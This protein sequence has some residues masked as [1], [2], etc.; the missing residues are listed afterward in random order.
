MIDHMNKTRS[1]HII[2]IEDPIEILHPDQGCIVNQR[3][4]G[5]DTTDFGQAL[6]R[7]LRQD[8]DVILIGELRD[9]ETAETALQAAESGHLVLSTMHTIDAAETVSRMV[10]FFPTGKQQQIRSILAGVLRGVISQRLLPRIGGGRVA[11]VEVMVANSRIQEL[12]R[13]NKPEFV[14]EAIAEG[15]FFQMQTLTKALIDLVISGDVDEETA[16]A[17]APNRHDFTIALARALKEHAVR[18]GKE[19][20]KEEDPDGA[21]V[22]DGTLLRVDNSL[23][24]V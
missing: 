17:A 18:E 21:A 11:A 2:T 14:P 24:V 23:R 12:I 7:A 10:E 20:E 13:E 8:P 6:R 19:T 1:Q 9:P 16:G 4:I 5:L 15:A 22:P 3:E